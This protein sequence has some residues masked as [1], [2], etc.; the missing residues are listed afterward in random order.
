MAYFPA[1]FQFLANWASKDGQIHRKAC[2]V[3][4]TQRKVREILE[5]LIPTLEIQSGLMTQQ[6]FSIFI[7]LLPSPSYR[8]L[9]P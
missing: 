7:R 6:L 8:R 2:A 5:E 9:P 1:I 4:L 3:T